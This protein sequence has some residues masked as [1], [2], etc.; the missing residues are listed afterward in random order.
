MRKWKKEGSE[1]P[2]S[3]KK[4]YFAMIII[5]LTP[6]VIAINV[7]YW[8]VFFGLWFITFPITFYVVRHD[9]TKEEIK[10]GTKN[11]EFKVIGFKKLSFTFALL[12]L[13][14]IIFTYFGFLLLLTVTSLIF[15]LRP[16]FYKRLYF[17]PKGF[18]FLSYSF[19][20]FLN[21][22]PGIYVA[23]E[24]F[25]EKDSEIKI[26]K[27]P[28]QIVKHIISNF[29]PFFILNVGISALIVRILIWILYRDHIPNS[30]SVLSTETLHN[31]GFLSI[32]LLVP[33]IMAIYFS[34]VWVWDDA[35]LKV[36]KA[37]IS[38]GSNETQKIK[39]T[40]LL[41]PVSDSVKRLFT[42]LFGISSI[43]WLVDVA[44]AQ[45]IKNTI[46]PG[47]LGIIE[48]MLLA[49][50]FTGVSTIFMG[51]M[52]YRSGVHEFLVNKLRTDIKEMYLQGNS[53]IK[54]CNSGIQEVDPSLIE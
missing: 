34:W 51:I 8:T 17:I 19:F 33:L 37:K 46:S 41:V 4:Y 9:F 1:M 47:T 16:N 23:G 22:I 38:S 28:F 53:S 15:I 25:I 7:F 36:A 2:P 43:I 6:W 11:D 3:V 21:L 42:Y 18:L 24:W 13:F 12:L 44:S 5:Y 32:F 40:T 27:S 45:N 14:T 35:E 29:E 20:D 30:T 39:E 26:M 31:W 54:I 48:L 49:F 52:Y 10:H 50:F